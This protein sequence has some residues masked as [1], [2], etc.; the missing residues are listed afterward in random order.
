V[1][2]TYEAVI[3]D[4]DGVLADSEP[5][6]FEAMR[7]VLA[8]LG[9]EV[10]EAH[11]R[12]IMGH[13]IDDTW[14]YLRETFGLKGPLDA[15]VEAYDGELQLMLAAQDTPLPGV[16][17]L[18]DALRQRRVPI[19]LASSSLPSWISALLGGLG[20]HD[21]FDAVVSATMVANPKP[22]PDIY[23]EAASRLGKAPGRCIAIED[24]PTG[25]RSANSAGMFTVQVRASST[26]WP[27]LPEAAIVLDTLRDF[28]LGLV[29]YEK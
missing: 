8:P 17:E 29:V 11:Q 10:T 6:Y 7:A 9:H 19:A 14:D 26:A 24:T 21:A 23:V 25:L 13:S 5:V 16:V 3:F 12:A 20:L 15:L 27:P 22:A 1:T 18:I 4:M 2:R 28:D